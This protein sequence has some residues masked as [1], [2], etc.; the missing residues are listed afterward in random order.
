[1]DVQAVSQTFVNML[2][3]FRLMKYEK[4]FPE[5][6]NG[7]FAIYHVTAHPLF[8]L[9]PLVLARARFVLDHRLVTDAIVIETWRKRLTFV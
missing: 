2:F 5:R 6:Q 3:S 7:G 4:I 9:P 8:E 1:M